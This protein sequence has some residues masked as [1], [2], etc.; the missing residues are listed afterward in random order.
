[1][2]QPISR[3]P[4]R[5]WI[6][7]L[8]ALVAT[9]CGAA[10]PA[11]PPAATG[12]RVQG[13][14]MVADAGRTY[15]VGA[16]ELV[17]ADVPDSLRHARRAALLV[18]LAGGQGHA[19]GFVEWGRSGESPLVYAVGGLARQR[20]V[21]GELLTVFDLSLTQYLGV[22]SSLGVVPHARSAAPFAVRVVVNE[23]SGVV[24]L[25]SRR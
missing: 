18:D 10:I 16:Y 15:R 20:D 13:A 19:R 6:L 5:P 22:P 9:G 8:L 7:V 17:F 23:V 21:G 1:M 4:L 3:I 24:T 11:E 2:N 12:R 25:T 14:S